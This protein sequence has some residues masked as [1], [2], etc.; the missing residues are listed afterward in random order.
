MKL[1]VAG[2]G[3]AAPGAPPRRSRAGAVLW[4]AFAAASG[5]LWAAQ[6]ERE[7]LHVAPWIALVPAV[8]LLGGP[9]PGWLSF[10]HGW[11]FWVAAI[12]WIVPT[13][14][15]FGQLP[16]ALS[17]VLL[18]GLA[19]YLALFSA[20][21]GAFGAR[22]WRGATAGG[23]GGW[24]LAAAGLPALFV[25]LEWVRG[26]LFSGFPWNLAAYAWVDVAG[27]LPLASWLGPW[28]VSY[29]VVFANASLA[30][31]VAQRR[32]RPALVGLLVPLTLLPLAGRFAGVGAVSSPAG[33]PVRVLQPNIA[34]LVAYDPLPVL[35]NY[36]R[37]FAMS[38][39]ACDVPGAL[40]V[41]P[42]SA[43]W[44][45]RFPADPPFE[46][47]VRTLV[48]RGCPL[49]LN[50]SVEQDGEVRNAAFLL[51]PAGGQGRYDKRHLVPFGEYV[52]LQGVFGFLD[53]LAR[54]AGQFSPADELTLLDW[55]RE[56]LGVA[57]CF[58]ITFP[59]EVAEAVRAGATS[60]VTIT[61]DAWYG[62][63]AAPWQ[64]FRAVRF[65]A[66]END[67]PLVRAAIT[68]VSALVAPDG[69][70][71]AQLGVFEEGVL[72]GVVRGRSR[73]TPYARLP[74]L[75]PAAATL[76]AVAALALAR[77]RG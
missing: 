17:W 65:R 13:L 56:R 37:L 53:T 42:E 50:S 26:W 69:R 11:A 40:L 47:D 66:A 52:P 14:V 72:R 9:R 4:V 32:W 57:I 54:E 41:W 62:D 70:V 16:A 60:L 15:T 20:A 3:T 8:L 7:A 6:F 58:E 55:G 77:R 29:L 36:R 24:V 25:A 76:L 73:L 48:A 5:W 45:Y 75:G 43:A 22:L 59:G 1:A 46:Q 10:V 61:N 35:R 28:G 12:P 21:F 51:D 18:A 74:W 19:A 34:N 31:A 67:R 44:P 49:L 64:H 38:E 39:R 23:A 27:A 2:R 30:L 68:G 33:Q 71:E 63:T